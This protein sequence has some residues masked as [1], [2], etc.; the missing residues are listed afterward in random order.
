[1]IFISEPEFIHFCELDTEDAL[2]FLNYQIYEPLNIYL[3]K[4]KRFPDKNRSELKKNY[5]NLYIIKQTI[6]VNE[7][8]TVLF[9]AWGVFN[10]CRDISDESVIH[11]PHY[12]RIEIIDSNYLNHNFAYKLIQAYQEKFKLPVYPNYPSSSAVSY[13]CKQLNFSSFLKPI[14]DN[15][16][17]ENENLSKHEI[18]V[19]KHKMMVDNY[20]EE[21]K[22]QVSD[23][24]KFSKSCNWTDE[25]FKLVANAI[26]PGENIEHEGLKSEIEINCEK[27][28][29]TYFYDYLLRNK[30]KEEKQLNNIKVLNEQ[31]QEK[32]FSDDD[33]DF[34][35]ELLEELDGDPDE[36]SD[37]ELDGDP[38][39]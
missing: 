30:G 35:H 21:H 24:E 31:I 22:I 7:E 18:I 9:L 13:W 15:E 11:K 4:D 20:Q 34:Y 16:L 23:W 10:K 27:Y 5:N 29:R 17:K 28:T 37:E 19:K 2:E 25:Y 3:L 36:E 38:E 1:M 14:S 32:P 8:S 6:T 33:F 39:W 12:A 26:F